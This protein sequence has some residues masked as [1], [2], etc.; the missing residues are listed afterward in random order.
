MTSQLVLVPVHRRKA[1][2]G[3][4]LA[5][6]VYVALAFGGSAAKAY[7][8]PY[9]NPKVLNGEEICTS[10]GVSNIRRAIG[11]SKSSYTW[12]SI[13]TG[14]GYKEGQC[15]NKNGCTAETG[16]LSKDSSGYASIENLQAVANTFYG[17]LYP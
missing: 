15:T 11:H 1:V 2:W 4:A 5:L 8:G 16:Y 6:A 10:S 7:E 14:A 12:V 17:Y 9:C 13:S 3:A